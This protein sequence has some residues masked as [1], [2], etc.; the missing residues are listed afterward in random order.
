MQDHIP[1]SNVAHTWRYHRRHRTV[2]HV[3]QGRFKSPVVQDDEHLWMVLRYIE[4][5]PLRARMVADPAD[6]P[7]SSY[8]SHGLGRPDPLLT[9][10]PEWSQ[11]GVTDG[12]RRA[13]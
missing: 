8:A 10:L 9:P 1:S 3:W 11:L 2:G 5:N 6:H 13:A 7:W 12:A 4:G